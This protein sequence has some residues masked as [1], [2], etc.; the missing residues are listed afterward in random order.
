M[1]TIPPPSRRTS[2]NFEAF[3]GGVS[4]PGPLRILSHCTRPCHLRNMPKH[5]QIVAKW[6]PVTFLLPATFWGA[7]HFVP[8][9]QMWLIAVGIF[10]SAKWITIAAV[11]FEKRVAPTKRLLAY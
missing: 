3:F 9:I 5:H 1:K 7:A 8:W 2:R 11:L 6:L 4:L 10:A